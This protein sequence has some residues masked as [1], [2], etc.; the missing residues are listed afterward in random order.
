[1][2][3]NKNKGLKNNLKQLEKIVKKNKKKSASF[4][5]IQKSKFL[6]HKRNE[7]AYM[8]YALKIIYTKQN[9]KKNNK[10]YALKIN[11]NNFNIKFM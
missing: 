8:K 7:K 1:M 10:L 3:K 6:L 5:E 4:F 9:K 11:N 2:V